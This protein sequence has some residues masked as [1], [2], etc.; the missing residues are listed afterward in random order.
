[1]FN[2]LNT[3]QPDHI[4]PYCLIA[5][6]SLLEGP[7]TI[8]IAGAGISLGK[9]LP[10]PAYLAVVGGNLIADWAGMAWD[11]SA[12]WIGWNGS[13]RNLECIRRM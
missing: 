1:M 10:L 13:A 8:L 9:L 2:L 5:L 11:C 6:A 3:A 12:S 4:L 7:M